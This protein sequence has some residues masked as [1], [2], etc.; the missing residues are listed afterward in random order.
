MNKKEEHDLDKNV[1]DSDF[2]KYDDISS[3]HN[4]QNDLVIDEKDA[5]L[6]IMDTAIGFFLKNNDNEDR[7]LFSV[8][9]RPIMVGVFIFG[10]F[11]G[12]LGIWSIFFPLDGAVIGHGNII[13]ESNRKV[14]QHLEGGIIKDILI[15]EGDLVLKGQALI[16][17]CDKDLKSKHKILIH[18]LFLLK[19]TLERLNDQRMFNNFNEKN[20]SSIMPDTSDE[21]IDSVIENQK[22]IFDVWKRLYDGNLSVYAHKIDQLKFEY[23]GYAEQL[24]ASEKQLEFHTDE[25]EGI[26]SLFKNGNVTKSRLLDLESRK[27]EFVGKVSQ[28]KARLSEL[29]HKVSEI[30]VERENFLYRNINE[31]EDSIKNTNAEI[32]DLVDKIDSYLDILNRTIITAPVDGIINELH[33]HTIDGVIAPSVKV[34][35]IIPKND[36]L[37]I[38]AKIL[39]KDVDAILEAQLNSNFIKIDDDVSGL[40]TRVRVGSYSSRNSVMLEGVL[41][42]LSPDISTNFDSSNFNS[43]YIVKVVVSNTELKK[44][45]LYPGMPVDI[46]ITTVSHSILSYLL[47]PILSTINNALREV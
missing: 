42:H 31:I 44:V 26:R 17:L 6:K 35:S 10:L 12:V 47:N 34:L 39:S 19:V 27:V 23:S 9:K 24:T 22:R 16:R 40:R 14:I 28:L 38:E 8:I 41:I 46:Y 43:Y 1:Q 5:P 29:L 11:F 18:K 37:I 20:L 7:T 15:K 21:Y 25:L 36:N 13:V 30:E 2:T 32:A 4:S 33:Y 45:I 3:D